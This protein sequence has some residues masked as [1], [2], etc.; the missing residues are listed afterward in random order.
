MASQTI[1][2]LPD[3]LEVALDQLPCAA[4]LL[5]L[6]KDHAGRIVDDVLRRI[7]DVFQG[8]YCVKRHRAAAVSD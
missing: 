4:V 6:R 7:A 3:D 5:E 8:S 1:D 2:R